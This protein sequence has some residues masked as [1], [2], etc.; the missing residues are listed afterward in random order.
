MTKFMNFFRPALLT[1]ALTGL[2]P[3]HAQPDAPLLHDRALAAGYKAQFICS[4]LWN[5]KK[6][7][8]QIEADELTGIYDRIADIVP[9]LQADIDEDGHAVRV[10][11]SDDMPPRL[12]RWDP[13]YGCVS[14]PIGADNVGSF[15]RNVSH[16]NLDGRNWPL[17]DQN[18]SDPR[19]MMIT[20]LDTVV[21]RAFD[22]AAYGGFTSGVVITRQ[23]RIIQERYKPGHD[24]HTAQRT[25]SVAKSIAGTLI[26]HSVQQG[27]VDVNAPANITQWAD[28]GDPRAAITLENLMRMA[29]GLT[30]DTAGNRTDEVYMGGASASQWATQW[31]LL[32]QQGKVFRYSNND[33]LLATMS[34][35]A[36]HAKANEAFIA[37]SALGSSNRLSFDPLGFF[38]KIGMTRTWAERDWQ[39][40]F[41]LSS[42]V[43]TTTRDL[44]RLGQ[45]YLDN[46]E[47]QGERLLPENW[48]EFVTRPSGPQPDGEFGYGATFWLMNSS[49]GVPSDAFAAFGN[50]GQYLVII[51]SLDLVIVRR[52]YDTSANRFDVAAFTKAVIATLPQ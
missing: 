8:A 11:Y 17:G 51:P 39:G 40:N 5:G 26:G 10:A 30:S 32:H 2:S 29:S 6:S 31:P 41:I 18:A 48:R 27:L 24:M 14:A 13:E 7:R 3:T 19:I 1:L 38:Q 45:L 23:G 49:D 33:I 43:W 15:F 35:A 22:E 16:A 12:T 47:W 20:P 34:I 50:R 9:Q 36:D 37:N 21:E 25:W 28:E 52:G 4:G 44:A 42:Q 46:G